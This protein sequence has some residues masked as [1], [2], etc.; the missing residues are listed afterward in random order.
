M[1]LSALRRAYTGHVPALMG[2]RGGSAVLLA[3]ICLSTVFVKQHS[4]L[5]AVT[6]CVLALLVYAAVRHIERRRRSA[7]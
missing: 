2:A 1:D 5:D 3:L 7:C 4:V 6:G